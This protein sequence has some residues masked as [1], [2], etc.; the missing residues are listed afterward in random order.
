MEKVGKDI[1]RFFFCYLSLRH[2]DVREKGEVVEDNCY[3]L[4]DLKSNECRFLF[5]DSNCSG[6]M[7]PEWYL[8]Q[9]SFFSSLTYLNN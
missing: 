8:V 7:T 1:G 3:K 6:E 2:K 9:S 5:C 4:S